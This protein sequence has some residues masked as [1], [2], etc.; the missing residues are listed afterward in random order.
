[1]KR[2]G[3]ID[4]GSNSA[5][6]VVTEI[7]DRMG[8]QLVYSQKEPLRL[9]MKT[10]RNGNL[11][12]EAFS[13][14]AACLRNFGFMCRLYRTDDIM[15]VATAAIRN[16]HNGTALAEE[17]SEKSGIGLK[18]I[19]GQEEARLSCLGV[20]N[21]IDE[22]DAVIFDE[23]GGST[24]IALVKDRKIV[25]SA[26]I[27]LGCANLTELGRQ[28]GTESLKVM[29]KLIAA[30]LK[31]MPWLEGCGLP[32]IGVG[33]TARAIGKVEQKQV[34]YFTAKLH[35]Y[36]FPMQDFKDWYK[37]LP[38][39]P[40]AERRRIPGLSEDRADVILAGASIISGLADKTGAGNFILS[41]CGLREGLF[42]QYLHQ[43][44]PEIPLVTS[45]VLKSSLENN[46][47]LYAPDEPHARLVARIAGALFTGWHSL[48]HLE[49]E[50]W[51]K[52]LLTAALL[53]DS[54][55]RI[56]FY[57]HTRHSGY[58][59]ENCRL[60]G[61]NHREIIF[62][63]IIAAWHHGVNRSYLKDKP[64]RKFLSEEDVKNLSTAALLLALAECLDY[65]QSGLVTDVK[66]EAA[67]G[68]A[69]LTVTARGEPAMELH[70]LNAIMPWI[71]RTLGCPVTV[72][73]KATVSSDAA[74]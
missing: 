24:E 23:G 14:T 58:L 65:T 62:S 64:Y 26:S 29:E 27:P 72:L 19:S 5:R 16:A 42:A 3:I 69:M 59:I 60:F 22:K 17:V 74:E 11:T 15:A 21:S 50:K 34:K 30:E 55:V 71:R 63:S 45:D 67:D 37:A 25:E 57:N 36:R 44:F 4:V 47:H 41:G 32:L 48:H 35:N 6:L 68:S 43:Q 40:P 28:H 66:A 33:G 61:L 46:L 31:K 38:D 10:D 8:C 70:Q 20:L 49:A 54:G 51:M 73:V 1:M 56:N 13:S 2:I 39:I 18:V 12:D 7:T 52:P 9:A 53:H